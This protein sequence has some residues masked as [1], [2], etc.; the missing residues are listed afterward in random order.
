MSPSPVLDADPDLPE[1]WWNDL[2]RVLTALAAVT[3][4]RVAVREEYIRRAV[5]EFTGHTV[6]T[7][8]WSTTHGDF[9]WA[10]LTGPEFLILDWEGWGTAPVGFDAALLHTYALRAPD[11]AARVRQTLAPI[12]DDPA[13]RV[14]ELTVCAQVLQ[15]ADRTPFYAALAKPVRHHLTTLGRRTSTV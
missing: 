7:I 1:S 10:N 12:L 15:A 8:K 3:T 13:V 11:T 14:A 4:D 2:G 5:P 6:D 9:H